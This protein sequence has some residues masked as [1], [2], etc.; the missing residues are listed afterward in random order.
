V[1]STSKSSHR[2]EAR[3]WLK[4]KVYDPKR[5]RT[6]ELVKSS[7]DS[8]TKDLRRVSLAALSARSKEIDPEGRGVSESGILKNEEARTY[9]EEHRGW[10]AR[11]RSRQGS[12]KP[13]PV[14]VPVRIKGDRD[15]ARVR[16]RY[17]RLNKSELVERLLVVEQAHAALQEQ[18][19]QLNEE[20]LS[21]RLRAKGL[22][23]QLRHGEE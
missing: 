13:D 9:Y 11:P 8:L 2:S 12:C 6:V 17:L 16:L 19:F 3:P 22:E 10:K 14:R 1:K 20:M 5:R 23:P 15:A 4:E 7:V 18:W 21:W